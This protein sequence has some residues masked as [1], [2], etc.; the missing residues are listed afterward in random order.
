MSSG[1]RAGPLEA[2]DRRVKHNT[3]IQLSSSLLVSMMTCRR[4]CSKDI[5]E[6]VGK[7]AAVRKPDR[8]KRRNARADYK[9]K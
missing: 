6:K 1:L 7:V 8:A 2:H 9:R 5:S 4:Q 3:R